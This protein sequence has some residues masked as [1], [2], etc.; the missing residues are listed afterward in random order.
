MVQSMENYD[1]SYL[2]QRIRAI[3]D[4]RGFTITEAAETIGVPY[5]T[6]QNQLSGKNKMPA[7]TYAKLTAMLEVPTSFVVEERIRIHPRALQFALRFALMEYLPSVDDEMQVG[8]PDPTRTDA[9]YSQQSKALA[10]VVRDLYERY[11]LIE[12]K[13]KTETR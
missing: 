9:Q 4:M 3:M 6:L 1:D 5:R 11:L 13:L 10:Y 8:P 12:L 2:A 7:S